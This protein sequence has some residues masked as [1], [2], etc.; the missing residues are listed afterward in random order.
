MEDHGEDRRLKVG[1]VKDCMRH[2]GL[3]VLSCCDVA[4]GSDQTK[5]TLT[6]AFGHPTPY[7]HPLPPLHPPCLWS[8]LGTV[9]QTP[10]VIV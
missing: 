2:L 7:H 3:H 1:G 10:G 5:R 9:L 8:L 6:I 4:P